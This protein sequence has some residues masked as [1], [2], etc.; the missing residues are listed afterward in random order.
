MGVHCVAHRSERVKQIFT[1]NAGYREKN[2]TSLQSMD[3]CDVENDE[4]M[5]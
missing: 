5:E 1:K 2:S 4:G 3:G